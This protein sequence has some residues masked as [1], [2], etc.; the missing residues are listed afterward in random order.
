MRWPRSVAVTVFAGALAGSLSGCGGGHSTASPKADQSFLN[1]VY[2][3]APDIS[4]YRTSKQL[5]NLGQV[6]CD[7]LESGATVQEVGDRVPLIEGN[8]LLPASDLGAV[9]SAAVSELCPQFRSLLDQ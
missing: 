7:D 8:V 3:G 9:I 5:V 2:S 1:S 6:V 4:S